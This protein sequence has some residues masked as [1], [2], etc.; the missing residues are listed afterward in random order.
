ME[1]G[2]KHG[3]HMIRNN[4]GLTCLNGAAADLA[5][6]TVL[7]LGVGRGGTSMAAG[8]LSKLGVYMGDRLSSRYQDRALLDCMLRKDKK[9][10]IQI[11]GERNHRFAL[12]GM[13]K[14]HMRNW[15]KLFREPVYVVVFRDLFAT[16]N[17]RVLLYNTSMVA[18]ML[19]VLG[20]HL[21]LLMFLW[22]TR[23][24]TLL[25]SYEKALIDPEGFVRGLCA[26][27]GLQDPAGIGA[28]VQFIN[29]APL[30]YTASPVNYKVAK[31]NTAY[32]GC[33]DKLETHRVAG[34]ALSI[35]DPRPLGLNL[36]VNGTLKTSIVANL[37]R[38]DV[39]R[40]DDRFHKHCGFVFRLA[41][42]DPLQKGDRVDVRIADTAE[43]LSNSPRQFG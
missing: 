26:F 28:A 17:R 43:A 36:F 24:P 29:P 8:A 19:K 27:L 42:G 22:R 5:N 31:E 35:A 13:K 10:A 12:W 21:M 38:M 40:E 20:L 14:L 34:W 3:S 39:L 25:V 2:S 41:D 16:A 18:E 30:E 11:I 32:F 7:V 23:R 9:Q 15:D 6:K 33:I 1:A 37:S 4:T